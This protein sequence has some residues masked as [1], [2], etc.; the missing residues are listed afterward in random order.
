MG[1]QLLE[2]EDL[3]CWAGPFMG[4]QQVLEAVD[5]GIARSRYTRDDE[6]GDLVTIQLV[7]VGGSI[8]GAR[9]AS[10]S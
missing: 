9:A 10:L 3:D 6:L 7:S 4:R 1:W 2:D 8:V 5:A